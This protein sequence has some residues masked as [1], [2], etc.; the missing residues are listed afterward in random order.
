MALGQEIAEPAVNPPLL[1]LAGTSTDTSLAAEH[2][3]S[4]LVAGHRGDLIVFLAFPPCPY[5]YLI[6]SSS[7]H[8]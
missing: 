3:K 4:S 8:C 7:R 6:V 2:A 1:Q 5:P